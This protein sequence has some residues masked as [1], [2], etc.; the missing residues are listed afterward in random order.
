MVGDF[1]DLGLGFFLN[2]EKKIDIL[3]IAIWDLRSRA[4]P[5]AQT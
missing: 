5:P 4:I 2:C 1:I 3:E